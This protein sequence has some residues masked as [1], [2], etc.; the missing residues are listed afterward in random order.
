MARI[1]QDQFIDEDEEEEVCPLCVEEFDLGD[2]YFRPCPCGYQ[3]CQFCYN[4]IKTTM[5]GLCPACRRP[6]DDK[7]FQFKN[8]TPEEILQHSQLKAA[9]QKKK[10]AA[11]QKEVQKREADNLSRK[12]LA[13]LRVRQKNL[14]YVTGMKPKIQGDRVA[15][16]LRGK[17]YFGQYGDIIKVVVSKSK[18]AA[19]TLNQPVGIY[20]TFTRKEDAAACIDAIN[21]AA[22]AGDGKI[23]AQH[24][25]TKYCSAYLRG[26]TCNNKSCMF[27]HEPGEQ[28]ESFTRQDLSSM[29]AAGTQQSIDDQGDMDSLQPQ[30]PPQHTQP[31]AAAM[32]PELAPSSPTS[33]SA[34]GSGLPA[35]ANWANSAA[36]R[37]SRATTTSNASP[38]VANSVPAQSSVEG[39][40]A[41]TESSV[42][43]GKDSSSDSTRPRSP[44][45]NSRRQPKDV[46][47]QN[48]IKA[49]FNSDIHF[50]FSPNGVSEEDLKTINLFPPLWDPKGGLKRRQM[51]DRKANELRE[52]QEA[53]GA[54]LRAPPKLD[55]EEQPEQHEH[56]E[57]QGGAGGSLQLGG[58]PEERQERNFGLG[59]HSAI[60]P[61]SQT[62]G[63][64]PGFSN[65][66][67]GDDMS[68]ASGSTGRGPTPSQ[69]Q[70]QQLLLQQLEKARVHPQIGGA[71]G[72]HNSRFAFTDNGNLKPGTILKQQGAILGQ[73]ASAYGAQPSV[74]G[75]HVFSSGVQGPPPGLKPTGTPPVS[76]GGMF[77]Q[78]YGF[79]AGYGAN[80]TGSQADK[81]WDLHRGQRVNQDTGKRELMFSSQIN[82]PSVSTQASALGHLSYPYGSQPGASAFQE[83][84]GQQKQKKKGKKHRHANTS[85]SGGGGLAD[86]VADPSTLQARLHQTGGAGMN[87][88]GLYGGQGQD[89]LPALGQI[90][91]VS[92]RSTPSVP[93]GLFPP[94]TSIPE[95]NEQ[96]EIQKP[97]QAPPGFEAKLAEPETPGSKATSKVEKSGKG[98]HVTEPVVPMLSEKA[99]TPAP[100]RVGKAQETQVVAPKPSVQPASSQQGSI[101]IAQEP[102]QPV[103]PKTV[104]PLKSVVPTSE[105]QRPHPGKLKIETASLPER[106][107]ESP[108]VVMSASSAK[109]D[110]NTRPSRAGSVTASSINSRPDT[111][112]AATISTGSP[113]RRTTQPRT[114]RI[115]DTPRAET[116]PVLPT[117]APTIPLI[118][119]AT[120]GAS[121]QA[122]RRPSITSSMPPGTPTS[123]RVDAFSITS[124][125][126]SRASSPPP[127]VASRQRK[128]TTSKKRRKEKELK[129]AEISAIITPKDT[130]EEVAPIQARK[131]KKNKSKPAGSGPT[132][133]HKTEA[134]AATAQGKKFEKLAAFV[135]GASSSQT[136]SVKNP[137]E[138][139]TPVQGKV[140]PPSPP[141]PSLPTTP[142]KDSPRV[143]ESTPS[144]KSSPHQLTPAAI[145]Q[146]LESTHQLAL[147]TLSLLKPL[148]QKSELRKLGID[149]F[150]AQDLQ[151]HI[152]QLRYELSRADEELLIQGKAVRKDLGNEHP[153]RISGRTMI[154]PLGVRVTCLTKEEEDKF[155]DLE[156]KIWET[157]GQRRWGGG[158]PTTAE[159]SQS[160]S[161]L[162]Q[163]AKPESGEDGTQK[164]LE[165]GSFED[166][167]YLPGQNRRAPFNDWK[168]PAAAFNNSFVPP[169]AYDST[170]ITSAP[171]PTDPP[172][173]LAGLMEVQ[174]TSTGSVIT[175]AVP[176]DGV[177][178]KEQLKVTM[179]TKD[180][181]GNA[182]QTWREPPMGVAE[183]VK[184]AREMGREAPR[185]MGINMNPSMSASTDAE[186]EIQQLS[187]PTTT[188]KIEAKDF[189]NP[190]H[191]MDF[192]IDIV[193]AGDIMAG[194]KINLPGEAGQKMLREWE[195]EVSAGHQHMRSRMNAVGIDG[196]GAHK[197][198]VE[199][200]RET[201]VSEKKLN[202]LIKK[203][204]KAVYGGSGY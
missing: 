176:R 37:L 93:P 154:S 142:I 164:F 128:E 177:P 202:A 8:V 110:L 9:Q 13:G 56:T 149:P 62:F 198:L 59:P 147:T 21:Q 153:Q 118:A 138:P 183:A 28:N 14:V 49:A 88:Q 5:N 22:Q 35:A 137:Q 43:S 51:K 40:H 85:S 184:V 134:P 145:M 119:A 160:V 161:G 45:A 170:K 81:Q 15:E 53:A 144:A 173:E 54:A 186:S 166:L 141:T 139:K 96:S 48:L 26:D 171:L 31:V 114:L 74:A 76:G 65:Y 72:R 82:Y 30:P 68:T 20:V 185:T 192:N 25:T 105:K 97:I 104:S 71:H 124:T 36:R 55:I 102:A 143:R 148:S 79:T 99:A 106:K 16:L 57:Q 136:E 19:Y 39:D 58:E 11:K 123:E 109:P 38:V 193:A 194:A 46:A 121:K 201:E 116:P 23:R 33:S 42:R 107:V 155:L 187:Q 140:K 80:A 200:R 179:P 17:E 158:K 84:S 162:V 181:E 70:Q 189:F 10:A 113:M 169:L 98:E 180:R 94:G 111:P 175:R 2:K 130:V 24:G 1:Q 100:K 60:Q 73:N 129:D 157:K 174:T 63:L 95:R 52:Q 203:N 18:D 78:G 69:A 115:T 163:R 156:A 66:M 108:N 151:N 135:K 167:P 117:P 199:S 188:G 61:P 204:R 190:Q 146:A 44:H 131:T 77:G 159:G 150:S 12:H 122:S 47:F 3:I 6:Y 92:R 182:G 103:V 34:D 32:Q 90:L 195:K 133:A 172:P 191:S 87:G 75:S 29:N 91:D 196:S 50:N 126:V 4:N 67:L 168:S 120:A 127:S 27:L 41:D 101:K 197:K 165:S 152:E 64:H 125:S 132:P 89:D 83:P 178:W 86:T 7:P 112:A